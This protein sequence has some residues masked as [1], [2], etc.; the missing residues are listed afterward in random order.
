MSDPPAKTDFSE[1][2]K[3]PVDSHGGLFGH[4]RG[5][6]LAGI[7]VTAPI[8]ITI[9]LTW[10]FLVFID[11]HVGQL[12]PTAYNPNTYMP[13]SVPGLG[14]VI[15]AAFFT[16]VG[17]FARNV[18][19]R[20]I[21]NL[22][23]YI[24]ARM[25][26]VRMVYG[27]LKQIFEAV[28]TTKA[29]SFREVVMFE[30]PRPEIW[31]MG[32]VT[33]ATKGEVQRLTND[34]DEVLNVFLPTTPAPTSGFLLFIPRKELVFLDMSVEDA[35]KLVVSA[36]ILTPPDRGAKPAGGGKALPQKEKE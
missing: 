34:G 22:S 33:G 23:E 28:M 8:S 27:A 3:R 1:L 15:A 10:G 19:G 26:G 21:I 24:V 11:D 9:Y 16:L 13:F 17:W 36:G 12:I 6:L 2:P 32:F 4:L 25:P 18:L 30:Y 5:Y 29:Q 20:L 31:A 14:L 7:L 35:F